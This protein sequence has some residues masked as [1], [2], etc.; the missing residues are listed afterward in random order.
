ML[1]KRLT[2]LSVGFIFG[3]VLASSVLHAF[4]DQIY[5]AL[6]QF[7][8]VLYYVE[9]DYVDPVDEKTLIQ[10]AIKGMLST[11]D[12]HSIYLTPDIYHELKVDTVGKFGGVGLEVTLKDGI[13][14]VVSPMEGTPADRAGIHPGDRVV[15]IDG[16]ITRDM[17][18]S[19]A[20]KKMR[21]IRKSKVTLTLYRDGWKGPR[22]FALQ[23]ETINVK[24]VRS[25]LIDGK[26]AYVRITSFQ[27]RTQEDLLKALNALQ[28]SA[29]GRLKG[30]IIDL[31]NNPGGLLD[32]AVEVSDLFIKDGIIVSTQGRTHKMDERRATG[33]APFPDIPVAI[34]VNGGSAS[35][36][37]IFAGA[38]QD[39]GRGHLIGTQTFGK[40][41]VQTVIDMGEDTGLKLTVARYYTP[42]NRRIDGKG[43]TPDEVVK[44]KPTETQKGSTA[45]PKE[46][47]DEEPAVKDDVQRK[48]AVDYLN[49][50]SS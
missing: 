15:K 7:S 48:A 18:L 29:N 21:G 6:E 16:Q 46:D 35:A 44:L 9:N 28:K 27:E 14:T 43:I 25:E 33:K 32:Q 42:K 26:Y 22:D 41:S 40:G 10:G 36:S 1:K 38:M 12:P 34:L 19:D 24:S 30:I 4:T 45:S 11:L 2:W 5:R 50:V 20:V 17:N 8:K 13:L 31:R 47:E 23:R 39:Y 37:E 49:K 3:I